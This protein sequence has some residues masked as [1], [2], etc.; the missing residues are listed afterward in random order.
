[1]RL[2]G[3]ELAIHSVG[4]DLACFFFIKRLDS[5]TI[6]K[7]NKQVDGTSKK[8]KHPTASFTFLFRPLFR[9]SPLKA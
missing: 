8:L 7:Q 4:T 3:F 1:M 2:L 6:I 9:S 5:Q